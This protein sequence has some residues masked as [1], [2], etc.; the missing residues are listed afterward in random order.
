MSLQEKRAMA[1]SKIREK[2]NEFDLP[3]KKALAQA[4]MKEKYEQLPE[5]PPAIVDIGLGKVGDN[6]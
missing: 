5:V 1:E 3:E 4:K 6:R 2:Y